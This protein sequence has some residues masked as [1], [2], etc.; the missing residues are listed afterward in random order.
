MHGV[1]AV[2]PVP[3]V[4]ISSADMVIAVLRSALQSCQYPG[5]KARRGTR[6]P[7][8]PALPS[9]Y[10]TNMNSFAGKSE[11]DSSPHRPAIY[12]SFSLDSHPARSDAGQ[13]RYTTSVKRSATMESTR[14]VGIR[15]SSEMDHFRLAADRSDQYRTRSRSFGAVRPKAS[16]EAFAALRKLRRHPSLATFQSSLG[17]SSSAVSD[18]EDD[19]DILQSRRAIRI[20]LPEHVKNQDDTFA[21]SLNATSI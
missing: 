18:S 9:D 13:S 6:I 16:D 10:R 14:P 21:S 3:K 5:T 4:S 17:P 2:R 20:G 7:E 8:R 1:E 11:A 12:T 15:S 19:E